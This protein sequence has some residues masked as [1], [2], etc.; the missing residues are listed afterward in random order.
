[1]EASVTART[2][3]AK[4]DVSAVTIPGCLQSN[5]VIHVPISISDRWRLR[6]QDTPGSSEWNAV[7]SPA[8]PATMSVHRL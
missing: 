5:D 1:M 6:Y 3:D 4:G 8:A 7:P 2:T